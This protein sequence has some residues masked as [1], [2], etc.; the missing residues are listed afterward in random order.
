MPGMARGRH[1]SM[2]SRWRRTELVF[3]LV[4][5]AAFYFLVAQKSLKL[6]EDYSIGKNS[7]RL[8]GLRQERFWARLNDVSDSQWRSFRENLPLLALV[9]ASFILI[10]TTTRSLFSLQGKGTARM[11]LV[12]S[13]VFIFYL[14]GACSFLMLTIAFGNFLLVKVMAGSSCLPPILWLYNM[15][16]LV[17]N[18]VYEGYSFS[19]I[20]NKFAFLD[21][22]RGVQRWHISFN[23]VMLRMVSFGLDYHWA[24]ISRA[25]T[26]DW[27]KHSKSCDICQSGAE[28]Y[29]KRQEKFLTLSSYSPEAYLSYL[30]FP[31]L[32][33][34]G[35]MISF[36][37][38]ASQLEYPQ[39]S[40]NKRDISLYG[41]RWIG[42]LLLMELLTHLFYFNSLAVS[43]VWQ[44]LLPWEIFV[45]GYG[46]LNFMWLKFLLIW[47]FFRFW[48]LVG[49]VEAVENMPHCINNCYDLEGFWKSWHASYNRWLVRYLY[50][51]LGGQHWRIL[52]IWIIFTFVA[53]WHDLEWKLLSWAWV[54]CLL[55]APELVVK[56][57]TRTTWVQ[58]VH[59]AAFYRELC[60]IGGS[61]NITGLMTANLIGFVV[62]PERMQ[63][64]LHT[65]VERKNIPTSLAILFSFYIGTKLMFHVREIKML[66]ERNKQ[67][68]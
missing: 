21:S 48:A 30:F 26:V 37:A 58:R 28:C 7:G 51:P 43:G 17:S 47:R 15:V 40:F 32:Y 52:N 29:L 44:N 31:P 24:C 67:A 66:R 14:H 54:T 50:I 3:L 16:F 56:S 59:E 57:L 39:T 6:A 13:L 65:L 64:L 60:A 2:A 38:F 49:G 46:V 4:Y 11:W 61:F 55:M 20:G 42:C 19:Q 18:R 45:V 53:I 1:S 41:L 68:D 23:F 22:H 62:G 27:E 12:S 33:I 35:P 9:M 36:N 8:R 10:N 5:A 25:S 63:W 34:A